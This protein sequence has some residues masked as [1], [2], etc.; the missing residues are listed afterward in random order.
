MNA[1]AHALC[2]F[3]A[4]F[5]TV[6]LVN[7]SSFDPNI[8]NEVRQ[9]LRQLS[10]LHAET[11]RFAASVLA[12]GRV[13]KPREVLIFAMVEPPK[14]LLPSEELASASTPLSVEE[15]LQLTLECFYYV[16]GRLDTIL[17]QCG[18]A[19]PGI[20]DFRANGVRR[21]RNNLIEHSNK[22]GGERVVSMGIAPETGPWLRALTESREI[23]GYLDHGFEANAAE[24]RANLE[25]TFR[26]ALGE[27]ERG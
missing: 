24:L 6:R 1:F 25:T 16:A 19:L 12:K 18:D 10:H 13:S 26:R 11:R 14:N 8:A 2:L 20:R 7:G 21:V 23:N 3:N 15:Q 22:P 4:Y 17:T 9:R 5:R 27:L